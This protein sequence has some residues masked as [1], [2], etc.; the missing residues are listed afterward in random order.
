ML[1]LMA[2]LGAA[3]APSAAGAAP[4]TAP[5]ACATALAQSTGTAAA[6]FCLGA[7]QAQLAEREEAGGAAQRRRLEA[8]AVHY[9]LAATLTPY[10]DTRARALEALAVLYEPPRLD[11]TY[12][13]ESVL[14]E[15]IATQPADA[16]PLYRLAMLQEDQGQIDAAET[17]LLTARHQH[18]DDV[19]PHQKLA[20]F[21]ARRV[22]A[23]H[24]QRE[25]DAPPTAPETPGQPDANGVYRVGGDVP[26][27]VR[28]GVPQYPREAQAAGIE[29][30]V[31]VELLIDE[32]GQ[33]ADVRV[34]RSIPLLDD[35][36]L[37][38]VRE[39]RFAPTIV[40]G[41]AVPVRMTATVNFTR[42]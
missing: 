42:R 19:E 2:S 5:A 35:A 15:L 27:P 17:T 11:D 32:A 20:Q 22:T 21:Y 33:V 14:R 9:R 24:T 34:L 36:A 26:A 25:R 13:L 3:Q 38:A 8:A 1:A 31:L 10:P 29:G 18:A 12:Q 37:Q 4:D 41:R 28:E 30:V 40:E 23:I 7:E 39:W 16:A 6:Q